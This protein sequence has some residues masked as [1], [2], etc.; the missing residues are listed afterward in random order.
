MT[1]P[2]KP[3]FRQFGPLGWRRRTEY[4]PIVHAKLALLGYLWWHDED[5]SGMVVDVIGFTGVRLWISSANFTRSSPRNLELGFWTEEPTLLDGAQRF[6]VQVMASSEGVDS[7]F[8]AF[9]PDLVP[10]DFDDEAMADHAAEFGFG[11]GFEDE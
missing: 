3:W 5:E 1:D 4:V 7:E 2:T 9:T 11:L 8:D 10:Y 6:L